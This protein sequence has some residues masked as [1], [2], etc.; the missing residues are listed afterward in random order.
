MFIMFLSLVQCWEGTCYS[1]SFEFQN[2]CVAFL[3]QLFKNEL[4]IR[5]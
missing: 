3:G 5:N 4:F 2:F 1:L